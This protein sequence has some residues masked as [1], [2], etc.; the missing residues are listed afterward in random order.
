MENKKCE[1]HNS[2]YITYNDEIICPE[3]YK[4]KFDLFV[5]R[6]KNK[7]FNTVSIYACQPD[8]SYENFV[9]KRRNK[10][11]NIIPTYACKIDLKGNDEK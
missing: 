4:E 3:C 2:E 7:E 1:K 5:E 6:C 10:E 11:I 9:E 8:F